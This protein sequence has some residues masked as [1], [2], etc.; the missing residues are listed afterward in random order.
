MQLGVEI[1]DS[2]DKIIDVSVEQDKILSQKLKQISKKH[3]AVLMAC[4]E[5]YVGRKVSPTQ[6][7]NAQ[8]G[9]CDEFAVE[10]AI[11]QIRNCRQNRKK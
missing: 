1:A 9:L 3:N 5:S 10:T 2:I 8:M 4:V 7:V 6:T 11:N